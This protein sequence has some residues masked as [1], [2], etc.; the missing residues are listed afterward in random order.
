VAGHMSLTRQDDKSKFGTS[1]GEL[2]S[3]NES[4]LFVIIQEADTEQLRLNKETVW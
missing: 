1:S 3:S 2:W 4:I